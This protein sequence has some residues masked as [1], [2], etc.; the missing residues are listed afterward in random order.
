MSAASSK[1]T[2]EELETIHFN[3]V[4]AA[5]EQYRSYSVSFAVLAVLLGHISQ[6][7]ELALCQLAQT[8]RFLHTPYCAS[9]VVE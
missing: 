6:S 5:F 2:D 4:V 9:K 1:P 8:K 7:L 3:S